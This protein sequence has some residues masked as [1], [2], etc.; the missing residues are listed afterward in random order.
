MKHVRLSLLSRIFYVF[1]FCHIFIAPPLLIFCI[2]LVP[3]PTKCC[4]IVTL[5]KKYC[6]RIFEKFKNYYFTKQI[7]VQDFIC[8]SFSFV[9]GSQRK[10]WNRFRGSILVYQYLIYVCI[11]Y[12]FYCF[13]GG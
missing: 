10:K 1:I 9:K 13:L 12:N 5:F 8:N 11:V 7:A 3:A 6:K 2:Q 4:R